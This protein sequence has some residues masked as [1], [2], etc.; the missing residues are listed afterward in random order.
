ME[1]YDVQ[2]D[3]LTEPN[4]AFVVRLNA[5]ASVWAYVET[6]SDFEEAVKLSGGFQSDSTD[7]LVIGD[8]WY[9][10][11][12]TTHAIDTKGYIYFIRGAVAVCKLP[13]F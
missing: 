11:N 4:P 7:N 8:S 9:T 13:D 3:Y 12:P 10:Y 1:D 2:F 6:L 5:A